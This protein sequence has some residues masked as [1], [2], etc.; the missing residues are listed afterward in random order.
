MFMRNGLRFIKVS[1]HQTYLKTAHEKYQTECGN[2]IVLLLSRLFF[3]KGHVR[4]DAS[5]VISIMNLQ[6]FIW[7]AMAKKYG[8][9]FELRLESE[10][11][12]VMTW[13]V[14]KVP[15]QKMIRKCEWMPAKWLINA[16]SKHGRM[17]SENRPDWIMVAGM[18]GS[19]LSGIVFFIAK[20]VQTIY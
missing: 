18:F 10:L 17:S 9:V 20:D 13:Q 12:A 2:R 15:R 16:I 6:H 5:P 8:F 4:R 1:R 7:L 19:Y 3:Y 11:N 14:R